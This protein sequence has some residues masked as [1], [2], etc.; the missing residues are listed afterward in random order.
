MRIRMKALPSAILGAVGIAVITVPAFAQQPTP[1]VEK[2][3][4]TGSNIKRVDTEGPAPVVVIKREDLERS[5]GQNLQEI[6][7][8]LS[9]ANTGSFSENLLAGNNFAPGTASVSLR[10]LGANT[11][12][13]LLNGRRLANYGFAQN[14]DTAFV[15]LN[16]IPVSAIE[17][18][19]ILKDGASA[20]YG[21]DAIAG[22]I[23]VILRKDFRG[24]EVRGGVGT[25][26]ESDADETRASVTG[27]IGDLAK[28]RFNVMA[29]VDYY[30]RDPIF[31]G[32]RDRTRTADFRRF[33]GID[34]R[35][36]SGSP[37]TWLTASSAVPAAQR[38]PTNTNF[39]ACSAEAAAQTLDPLGT[40]AYNF[41]PDVMELAKTERKGVFGR[42]VIDIASNLSAFAEFGY[43]ENESQRQLAPTPDSFTLPVGHNSNPYPFAVPIR[44]R[45][46]DVGPRLNQQVSETTRAV[47]GLK[48]LFR[49]W[50]WEIAYNYGKNEVEDIGY[51]FVSVPARNALVSN[52]NYSFVNPSQNDPSIAAGLRAN[53]KRVGDS[54]LKAID[55]K[56]AGTVWE[57]PAGPLGFAAGVERR[58]ENVKDVPDVLGAQ[59]LI[60][61]SGGT[62]ADGARTLTAGFGEFAVPIT[63]SIEAQFAIRHERYSDYGN[64][65]APKVAIAFR[66]LNNVLIRAGYNEGFR[67]PSLAQLYLGQS[68]S[69]PSV[70]DT[71]RCNG[72]RAAF[73]TAD[74][75]SVAACA[76][77]Q[78]RSV[79]GGNPELRA[80]D[81]KSESLGIVWDATQNLSLSLDYYNI[82]H[83]DRITT[84]TLAFLVA[85]EDSFPGGVIRD[86]AGPNDVA[87]GV[88]G[89]IVGSASDPR[90]GIFRFY[91]NS[92]SQATRGADFEMRYRMDLGSIGKLT[93]NTQ[94]TYIDYLRRVVAIGQAATEFAGG[95]G[96]PRYRGTHT[97]IWT[98][99]T[100]EASLTA[101]VIG[102]YSQPLTVTT[103]TG[104]FRGNVPSW[105]TLDAQVVWSGIKNLKL[106]GGVRNIENKEP[107]FYNND[108]NGYDTTLHN[109]IG[110]F[111]YGRF[112]YAFK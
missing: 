1:K 23:N 49:D 52:P 4:V 64:S 61:G 7:N 95:D 53:P 21:S 18:V 50:D 15:D 25:S 22:V 81:S 91:F 19:E 79:T 108:S 102:N 37:G 45:F 17:R 33:G 92:A 71:P 35:S 54:E 41:L 58:K 75:R 38:L 46:V 77:L 96:V 109:L 66:P 13:T 20:I 59:G 11:T 68:V 39:P 99:G 83:T 9:A 56:I 40:C 74:P 106:T 51:N 26:S 82:R 111:Y 93:L 2:I 3:E 44:Y 43:N 112:T 100:W 89:P 78:I 42:G 28:N 103:S 36:P 101:N 69:F 32:A 65:T 107:P 62:A 24:V 47:I 72:Y 110:R 97:A 55:A 5:G 34:F 60:I 57:L 80:E 84:P 98:R 70:T 30:K 14:I 63:K 105:T 104:T 12:L 88:R 31:G 94:N 6:L 8:G 86:P 10:G 48:G 16:S 90:V 29:T 76:A 87:A 67:A 85:N 73:G 27:G